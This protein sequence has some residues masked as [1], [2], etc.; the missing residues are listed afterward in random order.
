[1][2][3][4]RRKAKVRP[5]VLAA[6]LDE[7]PTGLRLPFTKVPDWVM[8]CERINPTAFRLWCIMRS[9][10]F[11]GGPGIPPV[12]LDEICYL[13]P[14]VNGKPTSKA[15]GREALDSLLVEGLLKDVSAPGTPKSAPRL[16]LALDEPQNG[17]M[18]FSGARRKLNR[19]TRLW[20]TRE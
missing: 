3:D 8:I 16:Y 2:P 18:G 4:V 6:F 11:E 14:G 17:G 7:S 1:M 13:L 12:T 19:Y 9:M 5:D 20:R 15:R 10:Q